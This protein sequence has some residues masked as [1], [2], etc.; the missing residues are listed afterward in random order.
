MSNRLQSMRF[1]A[2]GAAVHRSSAV[3]G[4]PLDASPGAWV[5]QQETAPPAGASPDAGASTDA[6]ASAAAPGKR[7]L[8]RAVVDREGAHEAV[9]FALLNVPGVAGVR[10]RMSFSKFNTDMERRLSGLASD[11]AA[12][13]DVS[14]TAMAET[15]SRKRGRD[16]AA[17]T[18]NGA[19][20]NDGGAAAASGDG[21]DAVD[22][23][24]GDPRE[25]RAGA[26]GAEPR[27]QR[28]S[29]LGRVGPL[30][31]PRG[32]GHRGGGGGHRGGGQGG[33][34]GHRGGGYRSPGA[35]R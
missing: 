31:P 2:K 10:G 1:M 25:G 6:A 28:S 11:A 13:P 5:V 14:D 35:S 24:E 20:G 27:F 12:A 4:A 21:A 22:D 33:G 26:S 7:R 9:G 19:D 29:P 30:R 23:V 34:G 16:E 15:L 18:D 32:G 17:A 8:F 3:P